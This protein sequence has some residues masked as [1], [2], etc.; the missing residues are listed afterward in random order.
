[1][2]LCMG[3]VMAIIMLAF[4]PGMYSNRAVNIGI[5]ACAAL[6]FTLSL[7]LVRSQT[8]VQDVSWM[9]AMIADLAD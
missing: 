4:M 7:R 6:V 9:T 8:T 1:M 2:A 5:L 3:A